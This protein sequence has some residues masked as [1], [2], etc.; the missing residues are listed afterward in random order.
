MFRFL[1]F[2]IIILLIQR[3]LKALQEQQKGQQE[4][5][6]EEETKHYFQSLGFPPPEE[7][8]SEPKQEKAKEPVIVQKQIK[9][10]EVKIAELKPIKFKLPPEETEEAEEQLP[11]YSA[12]KLEEGIILSEIL[13]PPKAYRFCRGGGIGIRAGLKN[14]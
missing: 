8:P 7:I 2:L 14:R 10:P 9:R 4:A 12:D 6:T 11:S 1:I 3:K 13:G 5:P